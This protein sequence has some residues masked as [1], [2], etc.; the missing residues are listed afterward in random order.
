MKHFIAIALLM[1]LACANA[2]AQDNTSFIRQKLQ[3]WQSTFPKHHVDVF[4]NQ[5]KY[6]PG[7]TAFFNTYYLTEQG[8]RVP[9]RQI[10]H[11]L[12]FS[13]TGKQ[14][15]HIN[16]FVREGVGSNQIVL[17]DTLKPGVYEAD[18]FSDWMKNF[19]RSLY[20]HQTIEVVDRYQLAPAT[21]ALD[22]HVSFFPE[23]GNLVAGVTNRIVI[24]TQ[25]IS[26]VNGDLVAANGI[27]LTSFSIDEAG[28]GTIVFTPEA[29]KSYAAY[30]N[31]KLYNLP[32]PV[33]DKFSV[34]LTPRAD[35]K[36]LK[37]IVAASPGSVMRNESLSLVIISQGN[38]Y[39]SVPI[40]FGEKDFVQ[41]NVPQNDLPAGV[42]QLWVLDAG[43]EPLAS[44]SFP[45]ADS[46]SLVATVKAMPSP[47]HRRAKVVAELTLT[48]TSG[49]P[50]EGEFAVSVVTDRLFT[51][52]PGQQKKPTSENTQSFDNWNRLLITQSP[53]AD[54]WKKIMM[55]EHQQPVYRM[56]RYF[57]KRGIAF[58][59]KTGVPVSD[60]V[61]ISGF[62]LK[63]TNGYEAYT[64]KDGEFDFVFLFDLWGED[65]LFYSADRNGIEQRNVRIK[66]IDE[67]HHFP[68]KC[69]VQTDRP[70]EYGNFSSKRKM[71]ERSFDFY[72]KPQH[73]ATIPEDPNEILEDELAGA[74]VSINIHDYILFPTMAETIREVIPMLKHRIVKG[75]PI[76]R[77]LINPEQYVPT[78]DPLYIIDGVITRD[79][80]LF[81]SLVPD[82][83]LTVKVVVDFDNLRALGPLGKNGVVFVHTKKL[84]A[85]RLRSG[86]ILP[87]KGLSRPLAFDAAD[88]SVDADSRRPDFKS[89]VFWAPAIVVPPAG[90]K[91]IS[92]FA[93]DDV[94]P[95][96]ITIHGITKDG[97]LFNATTTCNVVF[98]SVQK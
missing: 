59:A 8:A 88:H 70:D 31:E 12:L 37:I 29:G 61:K 63:N 97:R 13:C 36:P 48:D 46:A 76:V 62:F 73:P 39:V 11:L 65:E 60:S 86:T 75:K 5:T 93:S 78:D 64:N 80:E 92:F 10:L 81:L 16:F 96:R 32:T 52:P 9:G 24:K 28:L 25:G 53:R 72:T 30:I 45:V 17:P 44:R 79:T 3:E 33:T 19:D 49:N 71:V 6:S 82:D 4:F 18:L 42:A 22:E 85:A 83:V 69:A 23:G 40:Q 41:F 91:E 26:S 94:G 35:R 47:I 55:G 90:R 89:T 27:L 20:A 34:F 95:L 58:D 66:W 67:D 51:I 7:D 14:I 15:S 57:H 56:G 50:I 98:D 1:M 21:T 54:D 87:V 84:D 2:M 77:A 43:G 68:V 38:T 74:D